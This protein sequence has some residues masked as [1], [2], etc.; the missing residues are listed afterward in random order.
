MT[1]VEESDY[2][3]D[4]KLELEMNNYWEH[5]KTNFED[6]VKLFDKCLDS[7]VSST[8]MQCNAQRDSMIDLMHEYS[9]LTS[10]GE[11]NKRECLRQLETKLKELPPE[12]V[13]PGMELDEE[14]VSQIYRGLGK[15]REAKFLE[16]QKLVSEPAFT[17]PWTGI[18]TINL[19]RGITK[20]GEHN[21]S[22]ICDKYS[23]QSFRTPN[24]LA[25]K[26][27]KLK[28]IMLQDVQ[29]IHATRGFQISKWDWIQCYTHKLEVKYNLFNPAQA[30]P[31]V[32][33]TIPNPR[34]AQ[35]PSQRQLFPSQHR[36]LQ[37]SP[38]AMM[39]APR[40]ERGQPLAYTP[41][42]RHNGGGQF[43]SGNGVQSAERSDVVAQERRPTALEQLCN[44]Y[45]DCANKFRPAIEGGK[46]N[47]EE[48]KKYLA[49]KEA[50]PVYPKYFELH[51]YA[52]RPQLVA[53]RTGEETTKRPIFK[54]CPQENVVAKSVQLESVPVPI[55]AKEEL[56]TRPAATVPAPA[57]RMSEALLAPPKESAA[58]R[59]AST[60]TRAK[61][62]PIPTVRK[63]AS[64]MSLKKLFLQHKKEQL[65]DAKDPVPVSLV[66]HESKDKQ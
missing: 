2:Y 33:S 47:V 53:S 35:P 3:K 4:L 40:M 63:E 27:S 10:S 23:F 56:K 43:A 52:P 42:E 45:A 28:A 6:R 51:H 21:W 44:S 20:Y 8:G 41:T 18:E 46:F 64:S 25:Y 49:T 12:S 39:H 1:P 54:L 65:T 31:P 60:E 9:C 66:H 13:Q 29:K 32:P 30:H 48:V 62:D 37:P 14:T 17:D 50:A 16:R 61:A 36:N 19:L 58:S 24:S 57:V 38:A 59:I 34:L 55:P 5:F 22:E 26:W 7:C 11:K 15:T